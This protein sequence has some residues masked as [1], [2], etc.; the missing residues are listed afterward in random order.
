MLEPRETETRTLHALSEYGVMQVKPLREHRPPRPHR[1]DPTTIRCMVNGRYIMSPSPIPKFD[2]P[3]LDRSPALQ[4]YGAGREKRIYAVPPY[5][6]VKSLDFD[7]HPFE[8]ET[9]DRVLRLLRL[10][11]ELSR[12]DDRRRCRQAPVRLLRHRLLRGPAMS[13]PTLS[14]PAPFRPQRHQAL[15]RPCRLP[16][17]EL[18]PVAGRGAGHRGRIR[19]GQDD[20]AATLSAQAASPPDEG[21]GRLRDAH[22]PALS[23]CIASPKRA[24]ACWRAPSGAS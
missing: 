8:I 11:R 5:T 16:R 18:R 13:A 12:R 14:S 21:T 1:Q 2:N 20:L 10:H 15:R 6:P 19:L 4:L 24:A 9:L 17:R 3:K 7:D 23:T 22:R